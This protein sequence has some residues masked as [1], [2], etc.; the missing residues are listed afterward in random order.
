[1]VTEVSGKMAAKLTAHELELLEKP[2]VHNYSP[3]DLPTG[4]QAEVLQEF[5]LEK[6]GAIFRHIRDGLTRTP[7]GARGLCL[8]CND[9]MFGIYALQKNVAHM[10]IFD[11]GDRQPN[12]EPWHIEQTAVA[13]KLLG[14]SSRAT[15]EK[16]DYSTI[17][18]PYDFC[19]CTG[20]FPTFTDPGQMLA[21]MRS[22]IVSGP[23]IIHS[24][25]CLPVAPWGQPRP[26]VDV[27]GY[28]YYESPAE[29]RP[30]GSRFSHDTLIEMA[31]EAGWTAISEK[32]AELG[33][34]NW[35]DRVSSSLLCV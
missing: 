21:D 15:I 27:P 26:D 19:I 14:L 12:Y 13:A 6:Q 24:P 1:M 2:W 35:S 17:K 18:G 20:V 5:Q 30:W 11:V 25:T 23:L 9:G 8:T 7:K 4:P 31:V 10:D 22:W 28:R 16:R 34:P 32:F 33:R 3:V 29:G